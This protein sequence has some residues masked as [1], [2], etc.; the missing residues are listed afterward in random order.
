[1]Y[2][3]PLPDVQRPGYVAGEMMSPLLGLPPEPEKPAAVAPP[4][5][6]ERAEPAGDLVQDGNISDLQQIDQAEPAPGP[7]SCAGGAVAGQAE[8]RRGREYPGGWG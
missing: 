7:G 8:T 1:M 3:R 4:E 5:P 6:V 2:E